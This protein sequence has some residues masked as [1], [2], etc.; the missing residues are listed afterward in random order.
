MSSLEKSDMLAV[1]KRLVQEV[2]RIP[3]L[4]QALL[5]LTTQVKQAVS[6]D[7]C[8]LYLADY[9]TQSFVLRATDDSV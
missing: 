3:H 9:D 7:S 8:S 5:H 1:L 6:V 2:A 4:E